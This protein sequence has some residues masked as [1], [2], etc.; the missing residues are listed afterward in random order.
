MDG[1]REGMLY[2]YKSQMDKKESYQEDLTEK[3]FWKRPRQRGNAKQTF[4][5]KAEIKEDRVADS[6][7]L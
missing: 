2:I 3:I 6:C 7:I 1:Q 4:V 5:L